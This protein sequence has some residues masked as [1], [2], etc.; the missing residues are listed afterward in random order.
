M[1]EIRQSGSGGGDGSS[2]PLPHPW[3]SSLK[4]GVVSHLYLF[5]PV[6]IHFLG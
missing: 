6:Q 5:P 3:G 2:P 4:I 1:R